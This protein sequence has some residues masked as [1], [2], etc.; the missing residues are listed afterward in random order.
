MGKNIS[1]LSDIVELHEN[2]PGELTPILTIKPE[3]GTVIGFLNRVPQGDATGMPL[4]MRLL[5]TDGDN[6]P[7]DTTLV[8]TA[9]Q[10]GD[11]RFA[12][13]SIKEDNI[14]PYVNKSITEQ[15][16]SQHIDSVKVELRGRA[17]N[18]RDVDEF[19]IEIES[20]R[21]ID[22]DAGSEVYFDRNAVR[23]AQLR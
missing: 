23:E 2:T 13:V 15:Q 21:Q 12:P 10:P 3:E 22:W 19:A 18:V 20:D 6:L 16:D 5:D 1:H 4:F 11:S 14:S 9:R 7:V 17:V 8:L